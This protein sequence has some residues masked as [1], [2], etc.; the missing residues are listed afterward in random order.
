[1]RNRITLVLLN[2]KLG[3]I[4]KNGIA[5]KYVSNPLYIFLREIKD[6]ICIRVTKN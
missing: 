1:M 5:S 4:S 6:L 3:A 2:L